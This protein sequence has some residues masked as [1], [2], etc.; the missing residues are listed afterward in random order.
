MIFCRQI[1]TDDDCLPGTKRPYGQS[2]PPIMLVS[3]EQRDR[4]A[5]DEAAWF[6][7]TVEDAS[8]RPA[9]DFGRPQVPI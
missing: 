3:R 4:A 8:A 1:F 7:A 2:R 6:D 5:H 9:E